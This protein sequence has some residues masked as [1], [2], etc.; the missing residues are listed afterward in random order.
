M[1][2]L[3]KFAL[4]FLLPSR[5]VAVFSMLTVIPG[6]V[7]W[8]IPTALLSVF[9]PVYVSSFVVEG[10]VSDGGFKKNFQKISS[11]YTMG[12]PVEFVSVASSALLIF[13]TKPDEAFVMGIYVTIVAVLCTIFVEAYH[14]YG[15]P[16]LAK[17]I[18][19]QKQTVLVIIP[20]TVFIVFFGIYF[21][22]GNPFS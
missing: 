15:Y 11:K 7:S 10:I 12:L 18:L 6:F 1:I 22:N 14:H 20:F 21:I 19:S 16:R 3:R 13:S 5:I 9:F 4:L 2:P 8:E 17:T